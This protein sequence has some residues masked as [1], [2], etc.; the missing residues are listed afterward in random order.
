M[1]PAEREN[2]IAMLIEQGILSKDIQHELL[3]DD[4][5]LRL[6]NPDTM[7]GGSGCDPGIC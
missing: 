7:C 2:I 6:M 4:E 3:P 1:S 5:L